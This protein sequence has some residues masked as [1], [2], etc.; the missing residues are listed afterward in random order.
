MTSTYPYE[1]SRRLHGLRD[2]LQV[3][4]RRDSE[5]EVQGMAVP[6]VAAALN[7]IKAAKPEDP[8]V[9]S[10]LDLFSAEQI[11]AGDSIRAADLLVVVDQLASAIG[12]A[13][14]VA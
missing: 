1:A 12:T 14:V 9:Q 4:I 3:P 11:G 6:V 8:V 7:D 10:V 2:S 5:Q 13:P